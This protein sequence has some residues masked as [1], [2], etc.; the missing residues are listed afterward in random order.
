MNK[1]SMAIEVTER[2]RSSYCT[3]GKSS[4]WSSQRGPHY[5]LAL[6]ILAWVNFRKVRCAAGWGKSSCLPDMFSTPWVTLTTHCSWELP[7]IHKVKWLSLYGNLEY[8]TTHKMYSIIYCR[9]TRQ[10]L[11][12]VLTAFFFLFPKW[13]NSC[14]NIILLKKL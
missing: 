12:L 13:Q 14:K 6:V 9:W 11:P 2:N 3:Y 7:K 4:L 8:Q 5:H 10:G 1:V